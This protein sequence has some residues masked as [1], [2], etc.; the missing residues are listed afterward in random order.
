MKKNILSTSLLLIIASVFVMCTNSDKENEQDNM[1]EQ[2]VSLTG[3]K[4]E[5][6]VVEQDTIKGSIPSEAAGSIGTANIKI[7]YYAPGVKGRI[8]WGGLVPYDQVWATGAHMATSVEFDRNL[9]IG[10]KEIPAGKYALFT[11]P[12][13]EEWTVIINKNWEQH[14]TD[15]YD[16]KE[17][18]LR[19]AVKPSDQ[20]Q[21]QERLKYEVKPVLETEGTINISWDKL[22]I[23]VPIRT[24]P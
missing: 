1:Q 3:E 10:D 2:T 23:A 17:D 22:M 11:I 15:D 9:I 14:L 7:N 8:L 21:H 20:N 12:G 19:L 6:Q 4:S 5:N 13:R 24:K 16:Q 18:V